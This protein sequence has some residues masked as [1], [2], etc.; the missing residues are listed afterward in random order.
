MTA[1]RYYGI[2]AG[3]EQ[4]PQSLEAIRA[5]LADL[6]VIKETAEDEATA[7]AAADETHRLLDDLDNVRELP[8]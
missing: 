2:I 1:V 5:R 3:M 8:R 6:E 7:R 4:P